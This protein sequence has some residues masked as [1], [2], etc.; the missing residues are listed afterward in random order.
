ML[1][2][3]STWTQHVFVIYITWCP[4]I[5]DFQENTKNL[6]KKPRSYKYTQIDLKD[7]SNIKNNDL[8]DLQKSARY[9]K[10]FFIN[11]NGYR[12]SLF[13]EC[14]V[15]YIQYYFNSNRG[16]SKLQFCRSQLRLR[17]SVFK[18]LKQNKFDNKDKQLLSQ[19]LLFN[20][21]M[22]RF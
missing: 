4:K 18:Y 3:R 9:C 6:T 21:I 14:L 1:R 13:R 17:S 2:V 19:I 8:K 12:V 5:F 15:E 11:F 20:H 16:L 7:I 22:Y 10:Y